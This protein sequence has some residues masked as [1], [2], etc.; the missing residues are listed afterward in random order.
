MIGI[1][2][3][4][5]IA[6][7]LGI[8]IILIDNSKE[9]IEDLTKLLPGYNCNACGFGSCEGMARAILEN[10]NNYKKCKFLK[11]ESKEKIEEYLKN[12]KNG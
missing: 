1:I 11:G 5:L 8:L 7:F 2:I 6:L 10:T 4:T 3:V 12:R 9:E